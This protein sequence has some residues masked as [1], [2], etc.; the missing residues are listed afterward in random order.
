MDHLS[1]PTVAMTD[2]TNL[3]SLRPPALKP[4]KNGLTRETNIADDQ[5][6]IQYNYKQK[7]SL[8]SQAAHVFNA[9]RS[10]LS[11]MSTAFI[12]TGIHPPSSPTWSRQG[13]DDYSWKSLPELPYH[14]LHKTARIQIMVLIC[15]AGATSPLG[16]S[17][18]L[19][20]LNSIA[21]V[22]LA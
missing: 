18:I 5:G 4:Q 22:S 8:Q 16:I 1:E 17:I 7:S 11:R 20:A 6:R 21:H 10:D 9:A 14:C 2:R 15:L 3:E 13:Q 12:P 19:P